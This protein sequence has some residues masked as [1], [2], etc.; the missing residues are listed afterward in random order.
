MIHIIKLF[1]DLQLIFLFFYKKM[2]CER[3]LSRS[4]GF[5]EDGLGGQTCEASIENE[6]AQ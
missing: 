2:S 6:I 4:S 5:D 3:H 1:S